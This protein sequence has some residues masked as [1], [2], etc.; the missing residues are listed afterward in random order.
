MPRLLRSLRRT[1]YIVHSISLLRQ[2]RHAKA[3]STPTE[4]GGRDR[5]RAG[6]YGDAS[7]NYY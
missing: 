1:K 2:L 4:R 5:T 3:S 7:A 6:M